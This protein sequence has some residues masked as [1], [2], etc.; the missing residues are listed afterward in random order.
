[1]LQVSTCVPTGPAI[2]QKA[3]SWLEIIQLRPGLP[4]SGSLTVTPVALP[5]PALLTVMSNPILSP[6]ETG[7]SGLAVLVTRTSGAST[8]TEA[9]ASGLP[10]LVVVTWTML[11]TVPD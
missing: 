11:L 5:W 10:S 8:Q 7:P 6:A 9:F 4:G 1:M 3:P 2:V